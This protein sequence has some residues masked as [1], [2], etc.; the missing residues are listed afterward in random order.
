VVAAAGTGLESGELIS[1]TRTRAFSQA[2]RQHAMAPTPILGVG[3]RRMLGFA[4]GPPVAPAG[5]VLYLE[6]ALGPVSPPREAGTAP[7]SELD[8]VLYASSRPDPSAVL[9]ATTHRS[10]L[11]SAVDQPL[12]A[13]SAT[14]LLAVAPRHPLVGWVAA[15]AQWLA[16]A[17][18]LLGAALMAA[19]VE[20]A[21]RRRDAALALYDAEHQVAEKLQL[22]LLPDVPRTPGLDLAARYIAGGRSQQ[23]GGDWF[24]LF[25]LTPDRIGLVVGDVIGHDI[26]AASAMSQVR[27]A[28]RA[29]ALLGE[30]PAQV[31]DRLDRLVAHFSLTPLVTAVFGLLGPPDADGGRRLLYSNAGHPPPL[32]LMPDGGLRWLDSAGSV[33]IGAPGPDA[34]LQAVAELPP[35]STLILYTDG[36]L[37]APGRSLDTALDDLAAAVAGHR[38][39]DGA[40]GMCERVLGAMCGGGTRDDVALLV[41][42]L[43]PAPPTDGDQ[44]V[45]GASRTT[46]ASTA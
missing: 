42:H 44:P 41:I 37:E 15:H 22:S 8:V 13:G 40:Q 17:V 43:A 26:A 39:E 19:V 7:F 11:P 21:A 3:S 30:E 45:P 31:L 12:K 27:S 25:P 33:I 28:L 29:Y 4:M 16:L 14:W 23:V 46:L 20:M 2:L 18:G 36:L 24:D 35:G 9:V 1:D 38:V 10:I 34:R 32:L 6:I 5:T